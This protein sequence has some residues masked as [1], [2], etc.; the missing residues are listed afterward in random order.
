MMTEETR[1]VAIQKKKDF[2]PYGH[3]IKWLRDDDRS[4]FVVTAVHDVDM[5]ALSD[6]LRASAVQYSLFPSMIGT[7]SFRGSAEWSGVLF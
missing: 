5:L 2:P 4:A 6:Q 1:L 3:N 7:D